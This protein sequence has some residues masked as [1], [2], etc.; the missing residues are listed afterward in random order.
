ML[1]VVQNDLENTLFPKSVILI[2]LV[3]GSKCIDWAIELILIKSAW[4][5]CRCPEYNIIG[6]LKCL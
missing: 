3:L 6:E 4:I 1:I 2:L 5:N